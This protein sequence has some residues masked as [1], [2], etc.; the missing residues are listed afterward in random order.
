MNNPDSLSIEI[1]RDRHELDATTISIDPVIASLNGLSS[2]IKGL[3]LV[4]SA[5]TLP[6]AE[7][8]SDVIHL[9]E[10]PIKSLASKLTADLNIII[11]DRRTRVARGK[12]KGFS[13]VTPSNT[14]LGTRL[15]VVSTYENH[16][17]VLTSAH[18]IAHMLNVKSSGEKYDGDAHCLDSSCLMY[19]RS[20]TLIKNHIPDAFC[21]E[22]SQ[23]LQDN[24]EIILRSK[25]G[26]AV[27]A[28]ILHPPSFDEYSN[29]DVSETLSLQA[30]LT[31]LENYRYNKQ[32]LL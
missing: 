29:K 23:Q 1:F 15:A 10:L 28:H 26:E 17:P 20:T 31:V 4:D 8:S 19:P 27:P 12:L 14:S 2:I 11:A 24:S 3:D 21:D 16:E 22:C 6:L 32:R 18:E 9:D 30:P 5:K 25:Q 7:L 13:T